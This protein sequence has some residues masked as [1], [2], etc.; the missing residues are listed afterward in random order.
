[1]S[2]LLASLKRAFVNLRLNW[3]ISTITIAIISICLFLV[4][5]YFLLTH[6][7]EGI[8][9]T[10][11]GEVKVTVYLNDGFSDSDIN[12]FQDTLSGI[13]GVGSVTYT[14]KRRA[15]EEFRTSLAGEEDLLGGLTDNPLPA[16]MRIDP[17][18]SWRNPAGIQEIL[19][20]IGDHPIVQDVRYGR[21]WLDRL[22]NILTFLDIGAV[23][24][25]IIL[26]LA[27]IF[28]ISNTIKI[29]VM[30]RRDELEIMRYVGATEGFIR[31]P[32]LIEGVIQGLVG[33]VV[34]LG[35]LVGLH[36]LVLSR[37][38]T[39]ITAAFGADAIRFLPAGTLAAIVTGGII[40]GGVGS[41]ASVG[42]FS[43]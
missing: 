7:L 43:R 21:E 35:L 2:R 42:K 30:A 4:G 16:S 34:S 32:F 5:G 18:P 27:A 23:T 19:T 37:F 40:L 17:K 39:T 10:M 20:A 36:L 41:L 11:K 3:L 22:E 25:G 33:A 6:N 9:T 38:G 13:E 26:S 15:L 1:M 8:I 31:T 28:I 12:T 29:T 14:S 24:M